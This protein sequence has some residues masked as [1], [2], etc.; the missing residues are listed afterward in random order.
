MVKCLS[1]FCSYDNPEGAVRCGK[2]GL[3]LTLPKAEVEGR[4]KIYKFFKAIVPEMK[5]EEKIKEFADFMEKVEVGTFHS[6]IERYVGFMFTLALSAGKKTKE[7]KTK[8][9]MTTL[10]IEKEK[11]KIL[12]EIRDE[13]K[14]LK[15]LK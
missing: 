8:K 13:L 2:C 4:D 12:K 15:T 6:G 7:K 1:K 5:K 14:R 11:L 10:E 9:E 3:D